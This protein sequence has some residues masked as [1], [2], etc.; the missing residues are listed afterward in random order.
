MLTAAVGR[1]GVRGCSLPLPVP[2]PADPLPGAAVSDLPEL[3]SGEGQEVK[4]QERSF[5]MAPVESWLSQDLG[6]FKTHAL[7][8]L[9]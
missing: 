6:V 5:L 4:G 8:V 9:S 3:E 7:W 2:P 1:D